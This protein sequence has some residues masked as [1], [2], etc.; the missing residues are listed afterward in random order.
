M[1]NQGIDTMSDL[2]SNAT[3]SI[4]AFSDNLFTN[5]GQPSNRDPKFIIHGLF[6][7]AWYVRDC[8]TVT[9]RQRYPL[10]R[11][12]SDGCR[13]HITSIEEER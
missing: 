4:A 5:I 6:G 11:V 7:L 1:A 10:T 13:W 2:S 12:V 9:G 8:T 3:M